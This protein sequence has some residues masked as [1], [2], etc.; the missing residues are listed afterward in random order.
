MTDLLKKNI[1]TLLWNKPGAA[2]FLALFFAVWIEI[3]YFLTRQPLTTWSVLVSDREML[4]K[5]GIDFLFYTVVCYLL[6]ELCFYVLDYGVFFQRKVSDIQKKDSSEDFGTGWER[7]KSILLH[8]GRKIWTLFDAHPFWMSFLCLAL[9]SLPNLV[10]SWPGKFMGDTADQFRQIFD[11]QAGLNGHHPVVHTLLMGWFIHLGSLWHNVSLGLGLYS[12]LQ[13]TLF[14]FSISSGLS[15]LIR[16]GLYRWVY[17]LL[18]LYF[19]I[20]P[21]ID[22]YLFLLTKDVLYTASFVLFYTALFMV[23]FYTPE[24]DDPESEK[25]AVHFFRRIPKQ[26]WWQ[27]GLASGT[28]GMLVLRNE[29]RYIIFATFL[30]CLGI[31]NRRK[32]ALL[33]L[34]GALAV[35]FGVYSGLYTA[36]E[37]VQPTGRQEML[38]VPFQ[39]TAR[40]VLYHREDVTPQEASAIADV[41]D[42]YNLDK[43][44]DPLISDPVKSTYHRIDPKDPDAQE[45]EQ[46]QLSAY[47]EA[48][49]AMFQKQPEEYIRAFLY[50]YYQYFVPGSAV[51]NFYDFSWSIQKM[52]E[53][54]ARYDTDF[55]SVPHLQRERRM[56]DSLRR[57]I[58]SSPICSWIIDPSFYTWTA[59][60]VLFWLLGQRSWKGFVLMIPM[61]V[62]IAVLMVGPVNGYYGRYEFPLMMY[63]PFLLCLSVY[64]VR[65]RE[66]QDD[67]SERNPESA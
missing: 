11:S 8:T 13:G 67:L 31:R 34:L 65:N 36:L 3:G 63:L 1:R 44:Y 6:I 17:G 12:V 57:Q 40:Y 42:Y 53:I 61:L 2:A 22:M 66:F 49:L 29:G 62:N 7:L 15:C 54:N 59:L 20:T 23:F 9:I 50:N 47:F 56:Y 52:H 32:Q 41:L 64:L 48:W 35:Y 46:E 5:T 10:F 4:M 33:S 24:P 18:L 26:I 28:V 19:L 30:F 38:S 43:L 45:K 25:N 21:F 60:I 14:L 39:Q 27:A 55:S 16:L 37:V 58:L 51:N